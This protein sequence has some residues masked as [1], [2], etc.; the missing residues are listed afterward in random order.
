[1]MKEIKATKKD[2]PEIHRDLNK[3]NGPAFEYAAPHT[4]DG[5]IIDGNEVM[6]EGVYATDKSQKDAWVSDPIPNG[7]SFGTAKQ[8]KTSGIEMRGFGAA[9]KG[10]MSRGPM[11]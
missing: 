5:K 3:H 1:M 4:M 2:S 11:A 6:E 8:A 7:V 9:I 10:K